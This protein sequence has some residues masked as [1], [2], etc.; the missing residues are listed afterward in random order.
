MRHGMSVP[1]DI[2]I[3]SFGGAKRLGPMQH[4]LT[5]VTVDEAMIGRLAAKLLDEM[6]SGKRPIDSDERIEISLSFSEG[7][8][9]KNV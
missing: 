1:D 2:S 3:V 4:R 8:T 6:R 9:L 5:C 7:R